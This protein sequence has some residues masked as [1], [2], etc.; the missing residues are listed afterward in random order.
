MSVQANTQNTGEGTKIRRRWDW[1]RDLNYFFM[2][3]AE[4]LWLVPLMDLVTMGAPDDV[5]PDRLGNNLLLI[6]GNVIIALTLRRY[7]VYK[8]VEPN[9][10]ISIF[11]GLLILAIGLTISLVPMATGYSSTPDF[12]F[13]AAFK[14]VG[15][16]YFPRGVVY[17][18][19]VIFLWFRGFTLGKQEITPVSVSIQMRLGILLYFLIAVIGTHKIQIDMLTLMPVFFACALMSTALARAQTLQIEEELRERQFGLSWLGFI[20]ALVLVVTFAG[21]MLASVFADVDREGVFDVLTI[22]GTGVLLVIFILFAPFLW[23]AQQILNPLIDFIQ[24][25]FLGQTPDVQDQGTRE[26]VAAKDVTQID[27]SGVIDFL[28]DAVISTIGVVI[29]ALVVLSLLNFI[30]ILLLSREDDTLGLEETENIDERELIGGLRRAF[31]NQFKRLTD[32]LGL[33]RNFG[34][35]RGLVGALT[36]RW[37]YSRMER[38]AKKRGFPRKTSDTPYEYRRECYKAYPQCDRE[39]RLITEAYVGIRYGELPENDEELD[40][41]RTALDTLMNSTPVN[42]SV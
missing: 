18:P 36:I 20:I 17:I 29:I 42:P 27:L 41:V 5:Y 12:D 13:S 6:G 40:K 15:D 22:I 35:G 26:V 9:Q 33:L 30:Y 14:L 10:Q 32:A 3:I 38:E 19:I 1:R 2:T 16:E 11:F 28:G 31:G 4:I 37:A 25:A 8:R 23:F 24:N 7:M 34:V 21:Y 39:V